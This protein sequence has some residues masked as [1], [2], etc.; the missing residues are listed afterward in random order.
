MSLQQNGTTDYVN[1]AR[2]TIPGATRG[3]RTGF[4]PSV[5]TGETTVWNETTTL[6][7]YPATAVTVSVSSSSANDTSAGTGARTVTISGLDAGYNSISEVITLNGQTAVTSTL[8]YIRLSTITTITAGSGGKNAGVVYVG[9]GIITA[10]VPATIYSSMAIGYN[11]S[12]QAFYTVPAGMT[13]YLLDV[14]A[15]SDTAGT[16][17]LLYSRTLGGVFTA[18]RVNQVGVGGFIRDNLIPLAFA[19][20]TDIEYRALVATGTAKVSAQF[21]LLVMTPS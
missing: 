12:H 2:G 5:G 16:Q 19:A 9:T 15:T 7:A 8:S 13:A 4:N 18:R 1:V 21:E 14:S 10:G 6:V 17:I 20:K 11:E 3:Q